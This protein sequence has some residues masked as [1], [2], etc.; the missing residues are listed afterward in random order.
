MD[1]IEDTL[2][3][4]NLICL[5]SRTQVTVITSWQVVFHLCILLLHIS[6]KNIFPSFVK[7]KSYEN[8]HAQKLV[9]LLEN[10]SLLS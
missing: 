5:S 8:D 3:K 4:L 6:I 10:S 1:I 2:K 9:F 7:K